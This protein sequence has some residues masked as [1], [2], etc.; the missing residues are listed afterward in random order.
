MHPR[1]V[2]VLLARDATSV[3][4]GS[5]APFVVLDARGRKLHL[6][7]RFGRHQQEVHAPAQAAASAAAFPA[8]GAAAAGR[9]RGVPRRRGRQAKPGR[10]DGGEPAAARP[11]PARRRSVGGAEGLARGDVRGAG[12]RRALLHARDAEAGQGLRP[13]LRTRARRCTAASA[14]SAPQ[15]NLAVGATAGQVLTWS[16]R[17]DR[18]ASTSRRR[19]DG[20]RRFTTR[21]RRRTRCRT[22]CR[23]RTHTTTS[24]HITCGRRC[25]SARSAIARRAAGARRDATRV[26]VRNSSGRAQAVR[27]LTA[28]GWKR[29]SGPLMRETFRLGSTD[30]EVTRAD[31]RRAAT[32]RVLFGTQAR[33]H[34][35]VRGL[36]RARPQRLG[37]RGWQT[38]ARDPPREPS[39]RFTVSVARFARPDLG[40]P[41]T[42]SPA[43]RCR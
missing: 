10:T 2:R 6:P 18:R 37:E 39:G 11:L 28:R 31:A 5:A 42:A 7:A 25:S 36:G 30:F 21:G 24:R 27:L 26:V 12:G 3:R 40:S 38:V 4:V 29:F 16:G 35:W 19:A 20:R 43:T 14:P 41:T 33:V 1:P 34:G 22:S 17:I 23:W 8:G 15:T 32:P 9:L 13:L